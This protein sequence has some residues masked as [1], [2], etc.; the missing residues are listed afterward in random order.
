MFRAIA[1][2]TVPS[3]VFAASRHCKPLRTSHA[4]GWSDVFAYYIAHVGRA[5][6]RGRGSRAAASQIYTRLFRFRLFPRF[7]LSRHCPTAPIN[8]IWCLRAATCWTQRTIGMASWR[9]ASKTAESP[10]VQPHIPATDTIKV[11]QLHGLYLTPGLVDIH[12]HAY[13]GTGEKASYAG[14]DSLYPDGFT[15]REGVTTVVD[16]GSPD[17]AILRTSNNGSSTAPT[18]ACSPS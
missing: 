2:E 18:H 14:D 11:I 6:L 9:S 4:S 16:A 12:V 7:R 10:A 13:A 8:T 1:T 17:G 15:F 3:C 5:G